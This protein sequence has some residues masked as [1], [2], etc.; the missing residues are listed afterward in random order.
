[1]FTTN[2]HRFLPHE[3]TFRGA[4]FRFL[5]FIHLSTRGIRV[6]KKPK[7]GFRP[8]VLSYRVNRALLIF[9][10]ATQYFR[11]KF[12]HSSFPEI[13]ARRTEFSKPLLTREE[14]AASRNLLFGFLP[15]R[16]P[17]SDHVWT[18]K[19]GARHLRMFSCQCRWKSLTHELSH[20]SSSS[21][22]WSANR[23]GCSRNDCW[24]R[25]WRWWT[26]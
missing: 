24:G 13:S 9:D 18:N 5:L 21:N 8:V 16:G 7:R 20:Y 23:W 15:T 3:G 2:F 6:S 11:L 4:S 10:P 14:R 25:Y 17:L 22:W 12:D 1:M 26:K 19:I